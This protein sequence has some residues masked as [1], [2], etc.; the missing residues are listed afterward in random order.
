MPS[1]LRN[2]RKIFWWLYIHAGVILQPIFR[3]H[4]ASC[5]SAL[6]VR[7]AHEL[8][9]GEGGSVWIIHGFLSAQTKPTGAEITEAVR[10]GDKDS[11]KSTPVFNWASF[12]NITLQVVLWCGHRS[13]QHDLECDG[14]F[15]QQFYKLHLIYS[16]KEKQIIIICLIFYLFICLRQN[17]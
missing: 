1:S 4:K 12:S 13:S 15:I 2:T 10:L 8:Q 16:D 14:A 5:Q 9:R 7:C 3:L 6:R 11:G 17:K